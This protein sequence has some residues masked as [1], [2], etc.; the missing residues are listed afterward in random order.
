VVV[1][2][3]ASEEVIADDGGHENAL[4]KNYANNVDIYPGRRSRNTNNVHNA[5]LLKQRWQTRSE[6]GGG[7]CEFS[8][9]ST[10]FTGG[11]EIHAKRLNM[12][13]EQLAS[14]PQS[15]CAQHDWSSP[16]TGVKLL[17]V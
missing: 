2:R 13:G 12:Q 14:K 6:R 7:W 5:V 15:I 9:S 11:V 1:D 17:H 3:L 16:E 8:M 4:C 10:E